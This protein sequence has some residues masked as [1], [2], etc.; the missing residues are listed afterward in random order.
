MQVAGIRR[1]RAGALRGTREGDRQRSAAY[2]LPGRHLRPLPDSAPRCGTDR[3]PGISAHIQGM[4]VSRGGRCEEMMA[5]CV[6]EIRDESDRQEQP[7]L[8][9]SDGGIGNGIRMG[10]GASGL[11]HTNRCGR[12]GHGGEH[13]VAQ[14]R[15]GSGSDA[16]V[17]HKV[18]GECDE[19]VGSLHGIR[20]Q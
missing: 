2:P 3:L 17:R 8:S 12:E 1:E 15:D 11:H 18:C 16:R 13:D 7:W 6:L 4:D 5:I 10:R 14:V 20:P 9:L 19:V